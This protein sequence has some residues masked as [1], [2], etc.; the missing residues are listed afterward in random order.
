MLAR[1][2]N[3]RLKG[4]MQTVQECF[5]T[6]SAVCDRG[7]NGGSNQNLTQ[8][9]RIW[10]IFFRRREVGANFSPFNVRIEKQ[11]SLSSPIGAVRRLP[12]LTPVRLFRLSIGALDPAL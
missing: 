10:R 1:K 5:A 8:E 12:P 7:V 4:P 11:D 9:G 3:L 6:K 2:W